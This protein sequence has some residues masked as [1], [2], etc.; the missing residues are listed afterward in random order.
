MTAAIRSRVAALIAPLPS[1]PCGTDA[2][3]EP[4]YEA[5]R[6]E[7]KK[8]ESP[9]APPVD[10][11]VV[12]KRGNAL[13]T[14]TTKDLL[15]AAYTAHALFE[16][17]GPVGLGAGVLL[18]N[19]M[20]ETFWEGLFPPLAR[21]RARSSA[22]AWWVERTSVRL[23]T[24][25]ATFD[26]ELI[27]FLGSECERLSVLVHG[28]FGDTAPA[29]GPLHK[30]VERL[31]L[32]SGAPPPP[33]VQA[34]LPAIPPPAPLPAVEPAA[35]ATATA[36]ETATATAPAATADPS[37]ATA[38]A[39][40][41]D[42]P[43]A[44]P[45]DPAAALAARVAAAAADWLAPIRP[46]APAGDD[47]RYDDGYARVREM[48]KRLDSPTGL[49][50]D[51]AQ[52]LRD[53]GAL[54][55]TRSKDLLIAAHVAY[56]LYDQRG[57]NGLYSGLCLMHGLV[58]RFW[59]GLYPD[60]RRGARARANAIAWLT[61]RLEG[62]GERSPQ[63]SEYALVAQ[64]SELGSELERLVEERFADQ[65]PALSPLI[66]ALQRLALSVP[67]PT[68]SVAPRPPPAQDAAP[69]AA[70]APAQTA[71]PATSAGPAVAAKLPAELVAAPAIS[72][73]AELIAFYRKLRTQLSELADA[74]RAVDDA[75]PL[76]YR[77]TRTA[78][79]LTVVETIAA[80]P[81]GN[82]SVQAPPPMVLS[83]IDGLARSQSWAKVLAAGEQ[84]LGRSPYLLDLHLR[85]HTALVQLGPR[86]ARAQLAVEAELLSLLRRAPELPDRK[87][88]NG[89]PFA[90]A[91]TREWLAQ[92]G[93]SAGGG[94][95]GG[96]NET[97]PEDQAALEAVRSAIAAGRTSEGLEAFE[98]LIARLDSGRERFGA[99]L[100]V[101][102]AHAAA[103][104]GDMAA[105]LFEG[106][107]EELDRHRLDVWDPSL[108]S[109]CLASYYHCL[110]ALGQKDKEMA[111]VAGVVYRRLC[112]VDPKRALT[113]AAR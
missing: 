88:A 26:S 15:V 32:T 64:L 102:R 40:A 49:A 30:A 107:V 43:T 37:A 38:A 75:D 13:L 19:E 109:E 92:L 113:E 94:A 4:D 9:G 39:P 3:F 59:E 52:V 95:T 36:A 83:E 97:S 1:A 63:A 60:L 12:H 46:D 73:Q 108:A 71:S 24:H 27:G 16:C 22:L 69:A 55:Q 47:A 85:T 11:N 50:V 48:I 66:M 90:D 7:V 25:G 51:W 42:A 65:R 68:K 67:A 54:L 81:N 56:A 61:A 106:L 84:S 72:N 79:Y 105:A 17:E 57:L 41:D 101:A 8:L 93:A 5:L 96:G 18:L 103:G 87:F 21:M 76:P 23:S 98:G 89:T 86:H 45:A 34:P 33:P 53:G 10:W 78:C 80:G 82:T 20:L 14:T 104:S 74:L 110:K 58:D 28:R 99:R 91:A 6:D 111:Q 77:L 70:A 29:I 35:T 31:R 62:V 44:V 112:R 100:V 2:K